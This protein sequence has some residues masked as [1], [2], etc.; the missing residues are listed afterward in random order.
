MCEARLQGQ[1]RARS[2]ESQ[3]RC[4][5]VARAIPTIGSQEGNRHG[6][7]E[8]SEA[9]RPHW[10]ALRMLSQLILEPLPLPVMQTA[11]TCMWT[12]PGS[13]IRDQGRDA[14]RSFRASSR[15]S[16]CDHQLEWL[17]RQAR[18]MAGDDEN[19]CSRHAGLGCSAGWGD[20]TVQKAQNICDL[21]HSW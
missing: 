8:G 1:D 18:R 14:C 7:H 16:H 13:E 11:G 2:S 9:P 19:M 17:L 4:H 10:G 3:N 12:A 5:E 6:G 20:D 15:R 21:R